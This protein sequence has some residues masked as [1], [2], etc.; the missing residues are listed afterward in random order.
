[1][2]V[3]TLGIAWIA[4]VLAGLPW[5]SDARTA[6]ELAHGGSLLRLD[7]GQ[8][9]DV[10]API[11]VL[12]GEAA[13]QVSGRHARC[14]SPG[15]VAGLDDLE[16]AVHQQLVA[17][18]ATALLELRVGDLG[19]DASRDIL[20]AARLELGSASIELER[21]LTDADEVVSSPGAELIPGPYTF[22]PMP[23]LYLVMRREAE[24]LANLLPPGVRTVPGLGGRYLVLISDITSCRSDHPRG[25]GRRAAYRELTVFIPCI[26]PGGRVGLYAPELFASATAPIML[27]REV[28]GFPKR[29]GRIELHDR[30]ASVAVGGRLV[31]R[32]RWA[33]TRA[34]SSAAF[35]TELLAVLR[36]GSA[37][38]RDATKAH[39][40]AEV[41]LDAA[42]GLGLMAKLGSAHVFVRKRI[43]TA[44]AE[45]R[46]EWA[47]DQL[48]RIP[49]A[50]TGMRQPQ[51]LEGLSVNLDPLPSLGGEVEAGYC[52]QFGFRF[53]EG[54]VARDYLSGARP[55]R[56]WWVRA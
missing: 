21:A 36:K 7:G 45:P 6:A 48:V 23:V 28:Y 27:G 10:T 2:N 16:G 8:A 22:E 26:G 18:E 42:E 37:G 38:V 35:S 12:E 20:A 15:R 49:F 11:V 54:T 52:M 44:Q 46:L 5:V 14:L 30:G 32:A 47:I 24:A 51:R 1:M 17:L 25:G 29:L 19:A 56:R 41:A 33:E 9:I 3:P 40:I 39:P 31:L 50:G 43:P 55:W 53:G 4:D 34:L 13:L